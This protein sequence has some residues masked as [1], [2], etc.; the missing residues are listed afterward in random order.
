MILSTWQ[1]CTCDLLISFNF[2]SA[3]Q[4]SFHRVYCLIEVVCFEHIY[5]Y[6]VGTADRSVYAVIIGIEIAHV[7]NM[8]TY[9][10]ISLN[11]NTHFVFITIYEPQLTNSV[12]R[13]K[14]KRQWSAS[15]SHN[16]VFKAKP[17]SW[18]YH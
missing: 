7:R 5:L 1:T 13:I 6:G 8:I 16:L 12:I 9:C 15:D 4:V 2:T 14:M 11:I 10:K 17:L 18:T 3:T